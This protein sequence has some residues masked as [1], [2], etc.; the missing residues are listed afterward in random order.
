MKAYRYVY[1]AVIFSV[2]LSCVRPM[3][4]FALSSFFAWLLLPYHCF[5]VTLYCTCF[6][7]FNDDDDDDVLEM[8]HT[9][10]YICVYS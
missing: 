3:F 8:L 4:Y 5:N 6:D 9:C 2:S 7:E 10:V 1:F